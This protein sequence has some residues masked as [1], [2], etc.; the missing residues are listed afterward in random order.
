M[1]R[2]T[3]P[4]ELYNSRTRSTSLME[5]RDFVPEDAALQRLQ[6]RSSKARLELSGS[7]SSL[8]QQQ[9]GQSRPGSSAG[10]GGAGGPGKKLGRSVSCR[11]PGNVRK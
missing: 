2:S 8:Q 5:S 10:N 9:Q 3:T 11:T 1:E 4:P 6:E 7:E